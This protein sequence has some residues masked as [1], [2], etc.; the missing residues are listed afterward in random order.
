MSDSI[1]TEQGLSKEKQE[2]L[3]KIMSK[4]QDR[5]SVV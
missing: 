5:K 4:E 2:Q 1:N 3:K